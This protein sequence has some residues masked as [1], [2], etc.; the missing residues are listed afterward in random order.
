[1]AIDSLVRNEKG[2]TAMEMIG[3][4]ALAAAIVVGGYLGYKG[5][6]DLNKYLNRPAVQKANVIGG[7]QA[8]LFIDKDGLRFYSEIDGKPV[9]EYLKK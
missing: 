2:F 9:E 6:F 3:A 4:G 7:P 5:K 8:E 1:M